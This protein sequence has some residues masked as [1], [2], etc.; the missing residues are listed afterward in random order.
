MSESDR[1]IDANLMDIEDRV[2]VDFDTQALQDSLTVLLALGQSREFNQRRNLR[3]V[4]E[5]VPHIGNHAARF[6]WD[7][8]SLLRLGRLPSQS[9]EVE[10]AVE[11][12]DLLGAQMLKGE[13]VA[14]HLVGHRADN[15]SPRIG[16]G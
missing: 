14:R 16:T 6:P 15:D 13:P 11:A 8:H 7:Q 4:E 10:V 1:N 12:L 2:A 3:L 9:K 5:V